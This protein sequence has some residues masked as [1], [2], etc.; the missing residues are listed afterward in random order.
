[1][2][3]SRIFVD[4]ELSLDST[5]VL[6]TDRG[7]YVKNVLRLKST[8]K[9]VLF[10]GRNS[11]DYI[12]EISINGKRV[13]AQIQTSVDK[14]SDAQTIIEVI[15]AAGKPEH[16]DFVVQ[17]GTEL[18]VSGFV[19]FNAQ[20]TQTPFK[21]SRLIKKLAHWQAVAVSAC[22]QCGRNQLPAIRFFNDLES[23]IQ[24]P[25]GNR[26][27]MDFNG[28][29]LTDLKPQLDASKGFQLLTGCEGGLSDSEI[30]LA[31]NNNFLSCVSGPRTL[32]METATISMVS[33]VQ[34]YF[35]D[36]NQPVS[37]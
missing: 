14:H 36:M 26:L 22:E 18:G 3:L 21:G 1:M 20:R 4:L 33:I 7:H 19:F 12:A 8:N 13:E 11:A 15:Q 24:D 34:H 25:V 2:R 23:S 17:K 5:V 27:I 31:R 30:I 9:I 6:P 10:N 28:Q 16:M 29:P 32:R 35:G 37:L